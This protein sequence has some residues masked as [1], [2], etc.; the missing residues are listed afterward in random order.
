MVAGSTDKNL[1]RAQAHIAFDD[2]VFEVPLQLSPHD[3]LIKVVTKIHGPEILQCL[4]L[5]NTT[6]TDIQSGGP[7]NPL[8]L[9]NFTKGHLWVLSHVCV[10]PQGC[11][12]F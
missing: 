10:C 1:K 9:N 3:L 11:P 5:E 6:R 2:L 8:Q 12:E 4:Y 7:Y